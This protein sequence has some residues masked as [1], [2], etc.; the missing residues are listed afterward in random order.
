MDSISFMEIFMSFINVLEFLHT[1]LTL[2]YF[3][4]VICILFFGGGAIVDY[5]VFTFS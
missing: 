5:A 3:R 4:F 1:D 2:I